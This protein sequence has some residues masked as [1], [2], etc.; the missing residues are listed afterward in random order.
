MKTKKEI[1]KILEDNNFGILSE[2]REAIEFGQYTPCG[3]DW[4]ERLDWSSAE[5]FV[6][7]LRRRVNDFDIDEEV[8]SWIPMRGKRGV[9]EKITD[10]IEDATWKLE[11]LEAVFKELI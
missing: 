8:E 5:K 10:L 1:R 2:D 6:E 7:D 3:E 11:K 9:P 4:Y